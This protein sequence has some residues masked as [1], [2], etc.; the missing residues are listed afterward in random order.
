MQAVVHAADLQ[1]RDGGAL[2]MAALFSL[3]PFLLKLYAGGGYQGPIFTRAMKKIMSRVNIENVKR[4]D[5][6][7]KFVAFAEAMDRREHIR[8][9]GTMP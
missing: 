4:S 6:A 5:T 8:V 1:D 9:A 3:Y 2:V 7:K